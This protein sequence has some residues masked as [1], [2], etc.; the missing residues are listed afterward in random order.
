M[1]DIG[2]FDKPAGLASNSER[3]GTGWKT[4]KPASAAGLEGH[5]ANQHHA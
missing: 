5:G 4:K 1:P 3:S 2:Q